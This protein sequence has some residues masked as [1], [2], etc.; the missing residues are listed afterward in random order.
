MTMVRHW[1][2]VRH[3]V[4]HSAADVRSI[5]HRVDGDGEV[6][7]SGLV[8][9]ASLYPF[10]PVTRKAGAEAPGLVLH[11][12]NLFGWLVAQAQARHLLNHLFGPGRQSAFSFVRGAGTPVILDEFHTRQIGRDP[13]V[14]ISVDE[15]KATVPSQAAREQAKIEK[16]LL[17]VNRRYTIIA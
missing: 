15:E 2:T 7:Q 14:G 8:V 5:C 16:N 12:A 3:R 13:G 10:P 4:E 11:L 1:A 6:A 17:I 9:F